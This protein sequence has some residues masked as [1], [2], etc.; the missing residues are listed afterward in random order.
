MWIAGW[1]QYRTRNATL[2]DAVWAL[3]M[4]LAGIG[5]AVYALIN[6]ADVLAHTTATG[7][8]TLHMMVIMG[9]GCYMGCWYGRL[10][11]LLW[12]RTR[13]PKEDGRYQHL[14][15]YWGDKAALYFV[16]FF[17]IQA[18][19]AWLFSL[20]A[21]LIIQHLSLSHSNQLPVPSPLLLIGVSALI[22]GAWWGQHLS[23]QQLAA[24][25]R[26]PSN[27]KRTCNQ[28]LWRYS[29]HPNYFFEWLHWWSWPLLAVTFE[30]PLPIT[31]AALSAPFVM[32]LFLYFITGIPYTEQQ[33]IRTRGDDYKHYQRTTSA[34]IPW[35]PK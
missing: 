6:H 9:I 27:H 25:K 11:L 4:A 32:L 24:F 14:R 28:G 33:A 35:F 5:Y 12:H 20:P 22:V 19:L 18:A 15:A 30:A 17:Q 21:W 13:E 31:L 26:D 3:L 29:R 2:V 23:D 34:F 10:T 16:L 1:Y 8:T 7:N